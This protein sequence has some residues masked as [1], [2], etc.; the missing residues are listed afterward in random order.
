MSA[1]A[2]LAVI[3][4]TP[5][6]FLASSSEV[7]VWTRRGNQGPARLAWDRENQGAG[8]QPA[9]GDSLFLSPS[10]SLVSNMEKLSLSGMALSDPSDPTD[11]MNGLMNT[12]FIP[13]L[14]YLLKKRVWVIHIVEHITFLMTYRVLV[15]LQPWNDVIASQKQVITCFYCLFFNT[16]KL[17]IDY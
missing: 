8:T 14:T 17:N 11:P 7:F 10:W 16:K 9:T 1:Q 15:T 4:G 5:V 13:V 2:L 12:V 6:L 3:W